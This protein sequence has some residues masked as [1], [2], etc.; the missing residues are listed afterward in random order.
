MYINSLLRHKFNDYLKL[1]IQFIN[2]LSNCGGKTLKF[3]FILVFFITC[4]TGT[5][6]LSNN[7]NIFKGWS[8]DS[9]YTNSCAY[10]AFLTELTSNIILFTWS[11]LSTK[12]KDAV[13]FKSTHFMNIIVYINFVDWYVYFEQLAYIL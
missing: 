11:I 12:G 1:I 9:L 2:F 10:R 6:R 5:Q 8:W 7:D 3:Y 4:F 13:F